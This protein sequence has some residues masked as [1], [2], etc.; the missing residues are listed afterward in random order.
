MGTASDQ[1]VDAA[2]SW[3]SKLSLKKDSGYPADSNPNPGIVCFYLSL[4]FTLNYT[5]LALAYH[6]LQLETAAFREEFDSETFED[7][8]LPNYKAM[9]KVELVMQS[10]SII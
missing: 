7:L 9:H 10:S 2:E 6:N 8:T 1:L 4:L 3:I 5:I